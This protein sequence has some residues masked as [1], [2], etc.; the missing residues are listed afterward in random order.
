MLESVFFNLHAIKQLQ[1][2]LRLVNKKFRLCHNRKA[3]DFTS[4]DYTELWCFCLSL[5]LDILFVTFSN[6]LGCICGAATVLPKPFLRRH[7]YTNMY[8]CVYYIYSPMLQGIY[9]YIMVYSWT[10]LEP[11]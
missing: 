9:I 1:S 5:N 4:S 8:I 6:L 7:S 10:L 11:L 2:V 3:L